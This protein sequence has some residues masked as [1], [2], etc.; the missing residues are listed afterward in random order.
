MG[1]NTPDLNQAS[2]L[3]GALDGEQRAKL[4]AAIGNPCEETWDAARAVI[5]DR[6]SFTTLWQAVIAVDPEF[7]AVRGPS[8]RQVPDRSRR[9]YH[10]ERV[11]GWSRTPSAEV[12]RQAIGYATR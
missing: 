11:S 10:S 6:E 3:H 5:L 2:N 4:T 8:T 12:L 1:I 9:G 7:A